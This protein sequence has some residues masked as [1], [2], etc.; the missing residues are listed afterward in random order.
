MTRNAR[1]GAGLLAGLTLFV[2]SACSSQHSYV[3][4]FR[5]ADLLGAV[6]GATADGAPLGNLAGARVALDG[7]DPV[8]ADSR[9]RFLIPGVRIGRHRL[10]VTRDGYLPVSR[11][12]EFL[13]RS[14]VVYV[15]LVRLDEAVAAIAAA[16]VPRE[17]AAAVGHE[18]TP[19]LARSV[20]RADPRN[21][22]ARFALAV[23]ALE[24][25]RSRE[26]AYHLSRMEPEFR[27]STYVREVDA[28]VTAE[29]LMRERSP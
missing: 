13:N 27:D 15:R 22:V 16:F 9:G 23:L 3:G 17:N 28:L 21:P 19:A 18:D 14:Q 8:I 6:Y 2:I 12:I 1:L 26:A 25:G 5:K 24:E 4:S 29:L 11:D 10:E 20:L 7:G